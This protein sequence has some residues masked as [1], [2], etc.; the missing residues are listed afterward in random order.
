MKLASTGFVAAMMALVANASLSETIYVSN[1]KD[2]TI[3]VIDGDALQV[4]KTVPV[5]QRPRGILLSPDRKFL[6]ICASDNDR[7]EVLDHE[8][9]KVVRH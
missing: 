7:I 8:T 6:Y 5:G 2:N 3:T 4:T 1:E 9:Y